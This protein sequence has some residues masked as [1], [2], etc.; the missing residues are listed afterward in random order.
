MGEKYTVLEENILKLQHELKRVTKYN[1]GNKKQNNDLDS[2]TNFIYNI[3][4]YD[5]LIYSFKK[6]NLSQ[7]ESIYASNRWYN[8]ISA[9]ATERFFS[10]NSRV[11]PNTNKFDKLIDFYIDDIKFDHKGSVFPKAYG[12][13]FSFAKNHKKD[14][15]TWLYNNQSKQGRCHFSNRLFI[16]F[17]SKNG[18][19]WKLKSELFL[20]KKEIDFYLKNF[21]RNKLIKLNLNNKEIYSDIIFIRGELP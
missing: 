3:Y 20:I 6:Y 5:K 2:K 9:L 21:N 15:I 19:H 4:K 12:N 7:Y 11:R 16:I 10:L 1:W 17:Y 8:Y 18:E 14:L 13:T